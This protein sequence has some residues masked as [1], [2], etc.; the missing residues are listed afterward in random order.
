MEM[1]A[2]WSGIV[3]FVLGAGGWMIAKLLFEPMKEITGLRREAQECLIVYGNLSRDAP[4]DERRIAA[5]TFRRV[6]AGLVSRHIAAPRWVKW[7]YEG[8]LRWDVHSAGTMLIRIGDTTQSEGFSFANS[9]PL[10]PL[11]RDCLKLPAPEKPSLIMPLEEH[12][13]EPSNKQAGQL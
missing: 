12:S 1:S 9:S 4:A 5:Q 2:M 6:G 3:M 13:S 10:T 8:Y 7:C 11:I